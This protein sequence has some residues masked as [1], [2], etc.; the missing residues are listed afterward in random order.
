MKDKG[1]LVQNKDGSFDFVTLL[2]RRKN[3][4]EIKLEGELIN[5]KINAA[6]FDSNERQFKWQRRPFQQKARADQL[7]LKHFR[8]SKADKKNELLTED[9]RSNLFSK[10]NLKTEVIYYRSS[11]EYYRAGLEKL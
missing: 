11:D 10:L 8:E 6:H 2:K 5:Q 7:V 9:E 1:K 3:P 4:E